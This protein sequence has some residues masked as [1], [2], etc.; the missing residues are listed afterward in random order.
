M[1]R[2]MGR[3]SAGVRHADRRTRRNEGE[4]RADLSMVSGAE[5]GRS[6]STVTDRR[7]RQRQPLAV[8]AAPAP[9]SGDGAGASKC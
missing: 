6:R 1:L 5:H 4:Q 7:K 8:E 9:A 2:A 3:Q